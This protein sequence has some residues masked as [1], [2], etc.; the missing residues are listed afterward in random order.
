M[1]A[2]LGKMKDRGRLRYARIVGYF[3]MF[4]LN[5]EGKPGFLLDWE[6]LGSEIYKIPI[7]LECDKERLQAIVFP[8]LCRQER[9]LHAVFLQMKS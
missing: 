8:T 7:F 4:S 1:V 9:S 6:R 2:E 3:D 5:F